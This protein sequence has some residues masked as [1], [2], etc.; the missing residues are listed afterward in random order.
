MIEKLLAHLAISFFEN[1]IWP[2]TSKAVKSI[3]KAK[4]I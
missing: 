3:E 4:R 1:Q 2:I